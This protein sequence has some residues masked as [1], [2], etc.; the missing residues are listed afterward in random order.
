MKLHFSQ[1][2]ACVDNHKHFRIKQGAT[3]QVTVLS[4]QLLVK[5]FDLRTIFSEHIESRI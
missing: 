1:T 3:K 4:I 5:K 2:H